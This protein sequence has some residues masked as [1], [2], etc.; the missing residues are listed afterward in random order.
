ML[1]TCRE[2]D[3]PWNVYNIEFPENV[4]TSFSLY[5]FVSE[6]GENQ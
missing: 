1:G 6:F 3:I 5:A 2:R 4:T